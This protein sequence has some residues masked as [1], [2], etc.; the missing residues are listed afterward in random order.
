MIFCDNIGSF[1]EEFILVSRQI[2]VV[3][4]YTASLFLVRS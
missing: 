4:W 2:A 3:S 1:G